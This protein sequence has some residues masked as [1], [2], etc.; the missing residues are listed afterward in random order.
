VAKTFCELQVLLKEDFDTIMAD[1]PQYVKNLQRI[2]EARVQSVSKS[3]N[4]LGNAKFKVFR[5]GGAMATAVT[6]NRAVNKFKKLGT[7]A[8][9]A[10]TGSAPRTG[11]GGTP[12][13]GLGGGMNSGS[14]KDLTALRQ[15]TAA[16]AE[17]E[18]APAGAGKPGGAAL[19]DL[20]AQLEAVE[21]NVALSVVQME[22]RLNTKVGKLEDAL[23]S[24]AQTL[25]GLAAAKSGP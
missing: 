3:D 5:K 10:G 22:M 19:D 17:A 14:F 12:R 25:G 23:N 2:A 18:G 7:S 24:I 1:W 20:T 16:D 15:K 11:S 6:V 9:F 21:R 4:G 13:A 8:T